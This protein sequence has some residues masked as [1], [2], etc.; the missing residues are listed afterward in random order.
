MYRLRNFTTRRFLV[1]LRR[2]TH[3]VPVK[4]RPVKAGRV[5]VVS[6][7][8]DDETIGCGGTL[9][10]HRDAGSVVRVVFATN[11]EDGIASAEVA[12]KVSQMR[13]AEA[14]RVA[15]IMRFE[16]I[17][18]YPFRNAIQHEDQLSE[19]LVGE[20]ED[21]KPTQIFCT[22]PID[23]H[24]DHQA[25]ALAV[26]RATKRIGWKGEIFCFEVWS[27]AWPNAAVDITSVAQEKEDLIRMY[28]SQIEDRDYATAT[29]GL[30]RYRGLQHRIDYAEAFYICSARELR[31]MTDLLDTL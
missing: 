29:L 31:I 15:S 22:F 3:R 21:F 19:K 13:L 23:A 28:A 11:C 27:T 14:K 18:P 10:L 2:A 17:K 25:C 24:A 26:A 20:I 8:Y 16:S 7:H 5:L 30:N 12:K 1:K 6:P 4:L 9:L